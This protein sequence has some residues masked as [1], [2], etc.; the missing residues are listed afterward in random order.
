MT[1]N[2]WDVFVRA[3]NQAGVAASAEAKVNVHEHG[4][5]YSPRIAAAG[6]SHLVVW[7]SVGQDGSMEGVFGRLVDETTAMPGPEFQ[8]NGFGGNRQIHPVVASDGSEQFLVVWTSFVGG[9]TSFD[10]FGQRYAGTPIKPSVPFVSALSATRLSVTWPVAGASA[11]ASY[12]LYVDNSTEPI[13]M[14]GNSTTINSLAPNSTHTFKLAYNFMTGGKSGLSDAA[15]GTT[16]GSDQNLDG[17][18]DDWQASY[19]GSDPSKWPDPKADSDGDGAS[20]LQEF[21][22][23]T[24]PTD[25]KSVLRIQINSTE[26]GAFLAWNTKPGYIYQVEASTNLNGDWTGVNTPRLAASNE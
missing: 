7:T 14:T 26:Q 20:N 18:P 3:F 15:A 16:W 17:L 11:V 10:L 19:W 12:E 21:L 13:A 4:N 6:S 5:H 23:G 25:A 2:A 22:A 24:D 9:S 1:D 8:V